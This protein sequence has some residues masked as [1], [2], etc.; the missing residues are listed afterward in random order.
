MLEFWSGLTKGYSG[1]TGL[2]VDPEGDPAHAHDHDTG[3]V[4]LEHEEADLPR[5]YKLQV[6]SVV[7]TC[8]TTNQDQVLTI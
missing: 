7:R 8:E 2:V 3:H 4:C 1:R 5:Q 6:E